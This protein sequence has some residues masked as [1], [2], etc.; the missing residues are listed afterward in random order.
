MDQEQQVDKLT[1]I[2]RKGKGPMNTQQ[3]KE[4]KA[5]FVASLCKDPN[6]SLACDNAGIS[7]E[8]AYKWRE[9]DAKFAKAWDD[10]VERA[11][12]VG[13]SSIY[14]RAVH[15]WLE[16]AISL[17]QVV[18]NYTPI[19]DE[20]GNQKFDAQGRP[21]MNRADVVMIRKY[22]DALSIA[23]AKANLPEYK[24]K[25]PEINIYNELNAMAINAK[26]DLLASLGSEVKNEDQEQANQS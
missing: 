13:R 25:Q 12:D 23:W 5:C 1:P 26:N 19:L 3:R 24:D 20:N 8:I 15:G 2:T 4:A 17:K 18:Y 21:L 9:K 22:S 7:R 16:P 14:Q 10:A 6:V 11:R